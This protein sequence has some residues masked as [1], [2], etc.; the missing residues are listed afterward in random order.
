MENQASIVVQ[1]PRG[2][3]FAI[4]LIAGYVN[5]SNHQ[6]KAKLK[7]DT[8]TPILSN[9]EIYQVPLAAVEGD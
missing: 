4:E 9:G 1:S 6:V 8:W 5:A 2:E 7:G 3:R